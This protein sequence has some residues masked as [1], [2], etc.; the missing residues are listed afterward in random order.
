[1]IPEAQLGQKSL[2][3]IRLIMVCYSVSRWPSWLSDQIAFSN[4]ESDVVWTVS[5]L[6][7]W[8]PSWILELNDL[9]ILNLPYASNQVLAQSDSWFGRRCDLNFK[10]APILYIGTEWFKQFWISPTPNAGFKF[11]T[12][13][14]AKC[15]LILQNA[16]W[17]IQ[18]LIFF[19]SPIFC[20]FLR[21]ANRK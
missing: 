9:A 17:K 3:W 18:H 7:L 15:E 8:P 14:L 5:R 10:M 2:T 4:P 6:P 11:S 1:M 16:S 20:P 13:I 19:A 12:R 21:R